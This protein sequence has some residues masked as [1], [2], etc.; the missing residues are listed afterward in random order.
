LLDGEAN[1]T[2]DIID[3][4][5]PRGIHLPEQSHGTASDL[6]AAFIS[7]IHPDSPEIGHHRATAS[8]QFR[9]A[10]IHVLDHAQSSFVFFDR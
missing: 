10:L 3:F 4:E 5:I 8:I 1:T 7:N 2:T 9:Q 6:N